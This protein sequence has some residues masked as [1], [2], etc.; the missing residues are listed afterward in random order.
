MPAGWLGEKQQRPFCAY[1][2]HKA[3]HTPITPAPRHQ[4]LYEGAAHPRPAS[5]N[6]SYENKPAWLKA[7][8][9]DNTGVDGGLRAYG[10]L[11][12]FV[13]RYYRTVAAVDDSV[14]RVFEVLERTQQLENTVVIFAGDNG[15]F[16]GEHRFIN[17]RAMYEESIRIPLL[18]RY[19]KLIPAGSQVSQ[20]VLNIDI[21]PPPFSTS[22]A[23][24]LRREC[25][26]RG[27]PR[28]RC[29]APGQ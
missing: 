28:N 10:S 17:K 29:S 5:F 4:K 22:P 8:R 9:K 12:V 3:V 15:F 13:L 2:S 18:M 14:G 24:V 6:D 1:L 23:C 20:M 19:P 25:G 7:R 11:D 26:Y 16:L 27:Y 21:W